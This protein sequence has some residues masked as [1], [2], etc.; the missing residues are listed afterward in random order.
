MG[1]PSPRM[2]PPGSR[3]SPHRNTARPLTAPVGLPGRSSGSTVPLAAVA[4]ALNNLGAVYYYQGDY[5]RAAVVHR[6]AVNV[7]RRIFGANAV[8]TMNSIQ[9]LAWSVKKCQGRAHEAAALEE[10]VHRIKNPV[11]RSSSPPS[12]LRAE[13]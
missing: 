6:Q 4:E 1:V 5:A 8:A 10:V 13:D 2:K 3:G 9:W 11:E 12:S 7:K